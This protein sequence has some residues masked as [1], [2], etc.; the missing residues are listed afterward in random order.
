MSIKLMNKQDRY[1]MKNN[2]NI[3]LNNDTK[4]LLSNI[5]T[6]FDNID[7]LEYERDLYME[8]Y[9]NQFELVNKVVNK[10]DNVTRVDEDFIKI[11]GKLL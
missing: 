9:L 4:N 3:K 8:K 6:L 5:N 11:D 10:L 2:L 7:K 1:N